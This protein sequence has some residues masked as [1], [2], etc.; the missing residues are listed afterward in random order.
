MH[1]C[2]ATDVEADNIRNQK[3]RCNKYAFKTYHFNQ[4]ISFD[5]NVIFFQPWDI[6][7]FFTENLLCSIYIYEV[8]IVQAIHVQISF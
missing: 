6:N 8:V 5:F 3:V 4:R 1:L 2:L 7:F